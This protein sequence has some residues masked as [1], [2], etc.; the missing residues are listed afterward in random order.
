MQNYLVKLLFNI[1][2]DDENDRS[3]F[4]EQIRMV[5]SFSPEE[6]FF[7]ARAMGRDEESTFLNAANQLV[8][9]H[10]VDVLELYALNNYEDGQQLFS[11]SR[12]EEDHTTFITFIKQ[13]A[14]ELQTKSLSFA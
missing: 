6:A 7:K 12:K 9:W 3:Q 5:K 4:D 11:L 2:I 1:H 14:M 8:T 10:F 13:K